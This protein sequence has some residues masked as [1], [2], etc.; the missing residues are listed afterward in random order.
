MVIVYLSWTMGG[1]KKKKM[2]M[3]LGMK[4]MALVQYVVGTD[5]R[6]DQVTPRLKAPRRSENSYYIFLFRDSFST[7]QQIAASLFVYGYREF[8]NAS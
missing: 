4:S 8:Q 1:R 5:T 2:M 7:Q 6:F 3:V